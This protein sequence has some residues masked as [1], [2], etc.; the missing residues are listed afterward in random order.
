MEVKINREIRDF[1]E[2]VF[3]GMSLR[4]CCFAAAACVAAVALYFA[5]DP[6]L[7]IEELSW[8]CVLGAAPF[9]AAGFV[10]WHGMTA[11]QFA[12]VWIKSELIMPKRLV[13][14]PENLYFD[15]HAQRLKS[16]SGPLA[17]FDSKPSR[18]E[19]PEHPGNA[20]AKPA[21]PM[22]QRL[23]AR[24]RTLYVHMLADLY[25]KASGKRD[26]HDKDAL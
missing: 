15:A 21:A 1:S 22:P 26:A 17:V 20:P 18:A 7:G 10:R 6:Y 11:E 25:A 24:L 3:F 2:A 16:V 12:W 23:R 5:L 8:V 4:Q 19:A 13:S 9:A 14:R